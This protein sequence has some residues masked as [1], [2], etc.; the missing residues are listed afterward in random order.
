MAFLV[1]AQLILRALTLPRFASRSLRGPCPKRGAAQLA[2]R[3]LAVVA[4]IAS[5]PMVSA[6]SAKVR[7][8]LL[9][10]IAPC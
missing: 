1:A 4:V 2:T 5:A 3:A 10:S 6:K 8:S 7:F 9:K